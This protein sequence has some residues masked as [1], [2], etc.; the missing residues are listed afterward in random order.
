MALVR[1]YRSSLAVGWVAA[2]VVLVLNLSGLSAEAAAMFLRIVLLVT[3]LLAC[4]TAGVACLRGAGDTRTGM[5]VMILVNA[6]NVG[7]SWSLVRGFGPLPAL[8]FPGIAIGT[9]YRRGGRRAGRP[10]R[11]GARA[12]RAPDSRWGG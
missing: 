6:I 12:L 11:P 9:A 7:L 3:P 2:P 10:G 1:R 8:G 5:W 4:T